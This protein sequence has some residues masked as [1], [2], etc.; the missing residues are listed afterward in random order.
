MPL[1]S[2]FTLK[3]FDEYLENIAKAG[4]N[5]DEAAS[6][7]VDAG[8]EVFH[9]GMLK[10][11]PELTGHLKKQIAKIGPDRDGNYIFVKIGVFDVKRNKAGSSYL[12][13]QEMGSAHNAP[14]PY[15]R[16]AFDE[17]AAKARA[18]ELKSLKESG[19]L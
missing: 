8:A 3:G 18:A 9:A 1:K 6:K 15:I 19:A 2:S 14:H 12:F 4:A 10:R 13:Y 17:D 11:A 5:I 7:A 16:P